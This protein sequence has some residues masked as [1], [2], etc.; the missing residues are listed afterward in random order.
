MS[1]FKGNSGITEA[2]ID[3]LRSLIG[4]KLRIE[5]YNHEA[6]FDTIRHYAFGIGDDNPLWCDADYAARTKHGTLLAPPTFFFSCFAPGIAPGLSGLQPFQAGARFVWNRLARRGERVVAEARFTGFDE[7]HGKHAGRMIIQH[8]EVKYRTADGEEMATCHSHSYRA[9]RNENAEGGLSYE[10]QSE[11]RYTDEELKAI[12]KDIRAEEVRG[13]NPRYWEDVSVGDAL[14]PV[15]KGPLDRITMTVYY[16]GAIATSGYKANEIKWKQ[17]I[18]AKETPEKVPNNYD[19]T[20]FSER[21]LPSLGHQDEKVARALGMPGAYDNGHQRMGWMAHVLTNWMGDDGF[22]AEMDV[23]IRR[24]N[25]FG[26]TTWVRAK[27][28]DKAPYEGKAAVQIEI[29]GVDQRSVR[30]TTATATVLLPTR[31]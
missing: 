31:T 11:Y 13:A 24:P 23:R 9:V 28:V 14:T 20:Y 30:N 19:I 16:A 8:G 17:W 1:I 18:Q 10:P 15:V 22:L 25:I 12:E 26:N 5:Q 6:S 4:Q 7:H 2:M 27:V 3:E 29:E 21:V